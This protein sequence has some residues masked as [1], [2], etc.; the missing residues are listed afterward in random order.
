[1]LYKAIWKYI[2]FNFWKYCNRY[3]QGEV[4][5]SLSFFFTKDRENAKVFVLLILIIL[6][7]SRYKHKT[8]RS[9]K[10]PIRNKGWKGKR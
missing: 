7:I 5:H 9:M 8:S 1:M 4:Y 10:E 2:D 3:G 6:A